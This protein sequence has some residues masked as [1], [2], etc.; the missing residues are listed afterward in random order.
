VNTLVTVDFANKRD[1]CG[2]W[3]RQANPLS[4]GITIAIAVPKCVSL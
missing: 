1:A 3:Q 2:R 4:H